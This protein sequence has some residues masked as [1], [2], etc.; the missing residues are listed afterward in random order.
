MA[1][2][3][4]MPAMAAVPT[5][6]ALAALWLPSP[7]RRGIGGEVPVALAQYTRGV[8]PDKASAPFLGAPTLRRLVR[9]EEWRERVTCPRPHETCA[10]RPGRLFR[11][12]TQRR[13]PA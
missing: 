2:V 9:R 6:A 11:R 10:C 8:E 7:A 3:L 1:T 13:H 12:C 5:L 4:V